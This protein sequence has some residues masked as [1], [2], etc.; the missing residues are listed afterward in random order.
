MNK[1][2][3]E[4]HRK[5][6]ETA[7]GFQYAPWYSCAA[8]Q[9]AKI[10][11]Q[12]IQAMIEGQTNQRR[13]GKTA[14]MQ[15]AVFEAYTLAKKRSRLSRKTRHAEHRKRYAERV[16]KNVIYLSPRKVDPETGKVIIDEDAPKEKLD[17][18]NALVSWT[19]DGLKVGMVLGKRSTAINSTYGWTAIYCDGNEVMC[20]G[21]FSGPPRKFQRNGWMMLR[22]LEKLVKRKPNGEWAV[23]MT[24]AG[25]GFTAVW[26]RIKKNHWV[27]TRIISDN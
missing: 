18:R 3:F 19:N 5:A 21:M 23:R 17:L 27:V 7:W 26:M 20:F 16:A 14:A 10:E 9:F 2:E 6:F 12:R 22:H 15:K 1:K 8:R 11:E 4:A 25:K 13:Y 24:H